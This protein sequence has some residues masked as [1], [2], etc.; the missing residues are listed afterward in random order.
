M[1][2]IACPGSGKS[3]SILL[4][5]NDMFNKKLIKTKS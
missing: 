3:T 1:C 5:I 2:L 4:K